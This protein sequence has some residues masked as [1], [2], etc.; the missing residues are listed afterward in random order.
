MLGDETESCASADRREFDL[1]SWLGHIFLGPAE[2]PI[3]HSAFCKCMMEKELVALTGIEPVFSAFSGFQQVTEIAIAGTTLFAGISG[4]LY[5]TCTGGAPT[6]FSVWSL[7]S[8]IAG[9]GEPVRRSLTRLAGK[10]ASFALHT[11][12]TRQNRSTTGIRRK[13]ADHQSVYEG[14][15]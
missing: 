12:S 6:V 3:L 9:K 11:A 2:E 13:A 7:D 14:R 1:D 5:K 8:G 15:F 4:P 10:T